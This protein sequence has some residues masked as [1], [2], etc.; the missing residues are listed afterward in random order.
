MYNAVRSAILLYG[1]LYFIFIFAL[2]PLPI[3]TE[4]ASCFVM[5]R[6]ILLHFEIA[7]QLDNIEF[8]LHFRIKLLQQMYFLTDPN[9]APDPNRAGL[10][11]LF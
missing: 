9:K 11:F 2:T 6:S 7:L 8:I 5:K 1:H 10:I 4:K 3:K